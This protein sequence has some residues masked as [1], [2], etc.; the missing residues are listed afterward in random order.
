MEVSVW[1]TYVNRENGKRMHFDILVPSSLNDENIIFGYG[2][3]YL[4][5]KPFKTGKLT[6]NECKFCHLENAPTNVVDVISKQGYY[7]IEMQN[8]D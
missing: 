4:K 7:I 1:D 2:I 8:C 6:A 5:S 3:S